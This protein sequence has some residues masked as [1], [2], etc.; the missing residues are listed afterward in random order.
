MLFNFK[1]KKGIG[2]SRYLPNSSPEAIELINLLCTYDPDNRISAHRALKH[3]YFNP[4]RD[5]QPNKENQ[6]PASRQAP[7]TTSSSSNTELE[8]DKL[9]KKSVINETLLEDSRN[10]LQTDKNNMSSFDFYKPILKKK[11]AN[12]FLVVSLLA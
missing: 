6:E 12:Q 5:R 8:S 10:D 4:Y 3:R 7:A 9:V 11:V 2:I 1:P